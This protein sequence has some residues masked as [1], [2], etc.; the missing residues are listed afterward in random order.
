MEEA[1]VFTGEEPVGEG[2]GVRL[3]VAVL[4]VVT[5]G[6]YVGDPV[7][8]GVGVGETVLLGEGVGEGVK[9]CDGEP[10]GLGGRVEVGEGV[11]VPVGVATS[12]ST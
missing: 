6:V 2:D 10:L 12:A 11:G 3:I 8:E 7:R 1:R 9:D 5:L 4:V